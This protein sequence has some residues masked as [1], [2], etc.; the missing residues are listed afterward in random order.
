MIPLLDHRDRLRFRTDNINQ[1]GRYSCE[2]DNGVG[3]PALA[4]IDLRIRC[5]SLNS[6]S[7]LKFLLYT[8][9][10]FW[11]KKYLKSHKKN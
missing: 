4:T 8:S 5:K 7:F 3:D 6:Y 9:F 2:A 1:T 10:L 11:K